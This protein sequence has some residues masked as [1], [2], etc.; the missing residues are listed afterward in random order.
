MGWVLLGF[1]AGNTDIIIM[2]HDI[3]VFFHYS[4]ISSTILL[5]NR[6]FMFLIEDKMINESVMIND[7]ASMNVKN[8]RFISVTVS[9]VVLN[10]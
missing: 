6:Y 5:F 10:N 1:F 4:I 2:I 8:L 7:E 3:K 9:F